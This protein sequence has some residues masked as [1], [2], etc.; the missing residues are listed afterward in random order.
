MPVL[1]FVSLALTSKIADSPDNTA[2]AQQ[3]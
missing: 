1:L 2:H 3:T